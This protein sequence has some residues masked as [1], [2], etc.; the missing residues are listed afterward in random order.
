MQILLSTSSATFKARTSRPTFLVAYLPSN[1]CK[2]NICKILML[3]TCFVPF[4][5]QCLCKG[6]SSN[7]YILFRRPFIG[8]Y[9]FRIHN[10][11]LFILKACVLYFLYFTKRMHFRNYE[12]WFLFH[13]TISFR[14]LICSVCCDFFSLKGSN[15]TGIIMKSRIADVIFGIIQKPLIIKLSKFARWKII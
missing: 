2:F 5:L 9:I 15:E 10:I 1:L 6:I 12:N 4:L 8:L 14:F 3:S 13:L 7:F 11:N